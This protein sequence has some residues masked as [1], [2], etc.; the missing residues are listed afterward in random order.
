LVDSY[1]PVKMCVNGEGGASW[2][3]RLLLGKSS[4]DLTIGDLDKIGF[5]EVGQSL[6]EVVNSRENDPGASGSCL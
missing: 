6:S 2:L 3:R 4:Q 5:G 1:T